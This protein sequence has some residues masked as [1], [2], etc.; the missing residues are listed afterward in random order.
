MPHPVPHLH[1]ILALEAKIRG[2]QY[3]LYPQGLSGHLTA[4]ER[5]AKVEEHR[6]ILYIKK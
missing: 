4:A 5:E 6:E 1:E 2:D 3:D